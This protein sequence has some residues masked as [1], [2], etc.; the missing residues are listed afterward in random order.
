M[1][2]IDTQYEV[3]ATENSTEHAP[4][5]IGSKEFRRV[6]GGVPVKTGTHGGQKI[7]WTWT[8]SVTQKGR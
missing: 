2:H 8:E 3:L 7:E 5:V 6:I 1:N 4:R